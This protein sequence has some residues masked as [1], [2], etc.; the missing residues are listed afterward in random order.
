MAFQT[1]DTNP[2]EVPKVKTKYRTIQTPIPHPQSLSV[3]ED[4][5]TFE[6][7][8]MGGQPPIV[9][10]KARDFSVWDAYGN[11]W[12]D[13]SS[14]V[15]VANCGHLHEE[16]KAVLLEQIQQGLIHNYCFPNEARAQLVKKL[17]T[18]APEGIDKVFLLTTGAEAVENALKLAR[19]YGKKVGG[20]KKIGIVSFENAFHG[21]TLGAQMAGGIPALKDWI[22]NIDKDFYQV[23]YPDENQDSEQAFQTFL[24]ILDSKNVTGDSVAGCIMESYQGGTAAFTNKGFVNKMR[25]WCRQNKVLF[26]ADEVQAGFG[27][28][29]KLFSFEHYDIV[30]DV[31]CCGKGISGGLPISAV[32]GRAEFMDLYGPGEMTSTHS[33]NPLVSRAAL[34]SIELLLRDNLIQQSAQ[35]GMILHEEL[36]RMMKKY[37]ELIHAVKGKGLLAGI[38]FRKN[39]GKEFD[40]EAAFKIVQK[41]IHKGVMLYAPLGPGGATVKINPPLVI[42]EDALREGLAVVE[43]AIQETVQEL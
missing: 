29:G 28:T 32:L 37:P 35:K 19:T 5:H 20:T 12:L 25:Q 39:G 42:T 14:G 13:F 7:R 17:V 36:N 11:Q 33:G 9:W 10:H 6:P 43:E 2:K 27:R 3:L 8:S 40:S 21:R 31:I 34:K 24:S 23:P 22:V 15:L 4:L 1:F 38:H 26:I 30:P 16:V 41:C 18:I